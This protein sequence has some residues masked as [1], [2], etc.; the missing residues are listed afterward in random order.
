MTNKPSEYN[1]VAPRATAAGRKLTKADMEREG[2]I[3]K[4]DTSSY[5]GTETLY[6]GD[7]G[8]L[9]EVKDAETGKR[10]SAVSQ[11]GFSTAGKDVAQINADH[12]I[13]TPVTIGYSHNQGRMLDVG[14]GNKYTH[15]TVKEIRDG[16]VA[17]K[18]IEIVFKDK[19]GKMVKNV[20]EK[21]EPL[22]D[23]KKMYDDGAISENKYNKYIA[24]SDKERLATVQAVGAPPGYFDKAEGQKYRDTMAELRS[25]YITVPYHTIKNPFEKRMKMEYGQE[26]DVEGYMPEQMQ[27]DNYSYSEAL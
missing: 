4:V 18:K 17:S 14:E 9:L 6:A 12:V 10:K 20:Y 2:A 27:E 5:S 26:Y 22:P 15:M 11:Y 7:T 8:K 23:I 13:K 19:K 24:D 25:E 21:G 16:Y 1:L 3:S